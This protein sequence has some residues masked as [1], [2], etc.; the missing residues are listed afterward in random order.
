MVVKTLFQKIHFINAG[1]GKKS[2][3]IFSAMGC[4]TTCWKLFQSVPLFELCEMTV[5]NFW[6]CVWIFW[7]TSCFY[8]LLIQFLDF[9]LAS[10]TRM[11][12]CSSRNAGII[13]QPCCAKCWKLFHSVPL[14]ELCDMT[15]FN[16]D[17]YGFFRH[18]SSRKVVIQIPLRKVM[19]NQVS[20]NMVSKIWYPKYETCKYRH[21]GTSFR[22]YGIQNMKRASID[23]RAPGS[24]NM[25]SKIWNM[26]VST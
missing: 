13:F 1:W 7:L 2:R 3:D 11:D 8:L 6:C 25:V 20:E 5:L 17:A 12:F 14:L 21:K 10:T 23:V 19:K 9:N 18:T 15:V 22:K 4:H 24:E 16:F 26:Q